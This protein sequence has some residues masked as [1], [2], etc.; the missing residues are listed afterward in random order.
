MNSNK[1]PI[2][3]PKV[4][5]KKPVLEK[6]EQENKPWWKKY[7]ES[8]EWNFPDYTEVEKFIKTNPE[9]SREIEGFAFAPYKQ[10]EEKLNKLTPIEK[11][12]IGYYM[13]RDDLIHFL[14]ENKEDKEVRRI[15]NS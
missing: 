14:K 5:T 2:S 4:E 7:T 3:K 1:P 9:R 11:E 6:K 15:K 13:H 12:I 8:G 10:V